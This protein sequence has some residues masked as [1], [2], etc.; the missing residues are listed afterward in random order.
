MEAVAKALPAKQQ[1]QATQF[2]TVGDVVSARALVLLDSL[3]GE[4]VGSHRDAVHKLHGAPQ[5]VELHAL[6]HVHDAIAG[7]RPT[8]DGVLQE[9]AHPRQDDLEHGQAAAEPLLGQQ[10]ALTSDCDLLKEKQDKGEV[11]ISLPASVLAWPSCWDPQSD[12]P[13][14]C[15][16]AR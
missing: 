5:A 12:V 8:P 3:H 15:Q 10:V 13:V 4:L 11:R 6:V 2:R 7:Q 16:G 1:P 14:G 9:A